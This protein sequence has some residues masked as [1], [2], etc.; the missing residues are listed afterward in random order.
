[1]AVVWNNYVTIYKQ[2]IVSVLLHNYTG[3]QNQKC[4]STHI[5]MRPCYFCMLLYIMIISI[6][7]DSCWEVLIFMILANTNL[8]A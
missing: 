2:K 1:M 4:D 7:T 5:L 6:K 3:K 8:C